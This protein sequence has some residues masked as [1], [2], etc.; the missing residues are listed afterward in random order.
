MKF[1][2]SVFVMSW[3]G[4][5][6]FHNQR[7][8]ARPG[9]PAGV[10]VANHSSMIDFIVLQQ[11]N[12]YAVVGQKHKGWV[13]WVQDHVLSALDCVW[14][15]R[16]ESK[17]RRAV[18]EKLKEHAH[19]RTRPPLLVFPEG[20]CVNNRFVM[21]F[22]K[23]VFELDVPIHPIAIKYNNVRGAKLFSTAQKRTSGAWVSE[24][25]DVVCV[26]VSRWCSQVFV[27][28]YWNSRKQSFQMHLFKYVWMCG[29]RLC[30]PLNH[31]RA[32]AV[33]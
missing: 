5:I 33:I 25:P 3:S 32:A 18:A 7:P 29:P 12:S 27:D 16:G 15:N 28:A 31:P 20:T 9:Q 26:C 17:N 8:V 4:V 14:F 1:L 21:Q 22:K 6:R 11:T 2:C 10:F 30:A 13:G 19:D 23:G 24:R